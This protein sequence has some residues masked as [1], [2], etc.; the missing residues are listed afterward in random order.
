MNN[1]PL[2]SLRL[3]FVD[4]PDK[5]YM[6]HVTRK[7]VFGVCD[8]LRLKQACSASETSKSLEISAIASRYIILSEQRITKALIRLR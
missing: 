8:Q 3:N 4:Q 5:A 2:S 1:L 7:P 6:S